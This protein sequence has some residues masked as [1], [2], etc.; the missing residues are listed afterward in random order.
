[1]WKFARLRDGDDGTPFSGHASP[2]PAH[3]S[4][5]AGQPKVL[6]LTAVRWWSVMR[7]ALELSEV[8]FTVEAACPRG[9]QLEKMPFVKA[10]YRYHPIAPVAL[11]RKTIRRSAPMLLVPCD[12]YVRRQLHELYNT[13]QS[14]KADGSWLKA[15]IARSL[16]QPEHFALLYSRYDVG[17]LARELDIPA[18][19]TAA[20][21]DRSVLMTQIATLGLPAVLKSDWSW[22]G[23]GVFIAYSNQE[24]LRAFHRLSASHGILRTLKRLAVNRDPTLVVP[25]LRRH[26]PVVSIQR[27]VPGRPAN[28]A[29]ACWQGRV[30]ACVLVEVLASKGPKGPAT[31]VQVISHPGMSRAVEVMVERLKLSGLCGFDFVLSAEDD[32]AQL[33][34]INPRA[35]QT[36]YLIAAD[37]KDLL[38]ALYGALQASQPTPRGPPRREPLA[39]DPM[40]VAQ[41]SGDR[42]VEGAIY[43][44]PWNSPELAALKPTSRAARVD[45]S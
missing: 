44:I 33:V 7:L 41:P 18:P 35:T 8:G 2:A 37:G 17:S 32:T 36:C 16:G 22:A 29:V 6:I 38:A 20:I 39:L 15:L 28:A 24:A 40:E 12:D 11:L 26:R 43:D 14:D 27:F 1:M 25:C 10:S 23:G 45:P 4:S 3:S 9:S 19:P 21:G 31:V 30:L 13:T 5:E 34:E 42:F